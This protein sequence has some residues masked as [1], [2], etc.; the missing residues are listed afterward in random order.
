MVIR[1]AW[2]DWSAPALPL[3]AGWLIDRAPRGEAGLC[4]LS[5]V[6]CVLPGQRA[7]RLLLAQLLEHCGTTRLRLIPPQVHTPGQMVDVLAPHREAATATGFEQVLAWINVL[8]TAGPTTLGPL[9]PHPPDD[10]AFLDW[11]HL[12]QTIDRLH[13][14]LAGDELSFADVAKQAQTMSMG[15]EADRWEALQKLHAAYCRAL[16]KAG[17]RDPHEARADAIKH[18][19]GPNDRLIVLIGVLDLNAV[20]RTVLN[21][22]ADPITALIHAPQEL[23]DHF[24]EFGCVQP[25]AWERTTINVHDEQI[26]MADRPADQAQAVLR[27]IAAHAGRYAAQDIT[28]G[29]GD[30]S[31]VQ[32]LA[33]A[34]RW[35]GVTLHAPAGESLR[36]SAPF[37]LW[38]LGA[39]WLTERRFAHLAALLRHPDLERWLT[40]RNGTTFS[41]DDATTTAIECWQTI[42]DDY[43]GEYLQG[44]CT[45]EWL[46]SAEQQKQLSIAY[47]AVN[48]LFSPLDD[49]T[50][51]PLGHWCRG[52]LEVLHTLYAD[53]G[54][55]EDQHDTT[56]I[57]TCSALRDVCAELASAAPALCDKID[58]STALRLLLAQAGSRRI[59][60][61]PRRGQIEMLGWLELH[62]DTAPALVVTG[63]TEGCVPQS[64]TADAFLPDALRRAL[65][66]TDNTRRYARDAYILKALLNSRQDVTIILNR[67]TDD[68]EP[69]A[70]SRLLLACPR[71]QLAE[72]V[73]ALCGA[74]EMRPWVHP[75][76]VDAPAA[77]SRFDTPHLP[78][79]LDVPE[80]I[81][82][83]WF[84]EYL[85]CPYRFALRRLMKLTGRADDATEL[86]AG[87]FGSVAHQVLRMFGE[88]GEIA[89]CDDAA[90]IASFL[91]STL[92]T[93]VKQRYGDHPMPAVQVQVS[94]LRQRLERFAQYQAQRRADGWKIERCEYELPSSSVLEVPGQSPMRIT[95]R[96]DRIDRHEKTNEWCIIDY[97]TSESAKTPD[98]AHRGR[99]FFGGE[100]IDVQ[101]PLYQHLAAQH[102]IDGAVSLAYLTMPKDPAGVE[103]RP[104]LW[105]K[106]QLKEAIE[107]ARTVLT[108]IRQ[109]AFEMNHDLGKSYDD[110]ARICQTTAFVTEAQGGD[111]P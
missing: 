6:V 98:K 37:R 4:D 8:R 57:E 100:W 42:L 47:D 79:D 80:S 59:P 107:T 10:S 109:G 36:R 21:T 101:L 2:L 39:D 11:Y 97:K 14:E 16:S 94:R 52:A 106:D 69:L 3:A 105:N 89:D 90:R 40:A 44:K 32:V 45:G 93:L 81:P 104:A 1:R 68:D 30:E 22:V 46:G 29:L 23:A 50:P 85:L 26:V 7:G 41:N 56:L 17:L 86:D 91:A 64:L 19:A 78:T 25:S 62:L 43:F 51:R 71:S 70:P 34:G 38:Q 102:G 65:G 60:Q 33:Q 95:G 27:A 83:T 110:F 31:Q 75:I 77:V 82:V 13:E 74:P 103:V 67:R 9:L 12:A 28:I 76:G 87:Q 111:D 96:I 48:E 5:K 108:N 24:D 35:A 15:G 53:G 18:A 61:D 54:S 99:N 84:R 55:Q 92:Q 72:R 88:D 63:F 58:G 49:A 73:Q 66:L 20:Q